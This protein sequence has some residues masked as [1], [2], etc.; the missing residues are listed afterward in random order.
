MI[1]LILHDSSKKKDKQIH[2][3]DE[4]ETRVSTSIDRRQFPIV[5]SAAIRIE[6]ESN[7]NNVQNCS[8][9]FFPIKI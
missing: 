5:Q 9:S 8:K 1:E 6:I 7:L 3:D 4:T 2:G